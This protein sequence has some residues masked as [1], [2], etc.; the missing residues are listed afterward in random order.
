VYFL[1]DPEA[2]FNVMVNERLSSRTTFSQPCSNRHTRRL[3]ARVL[4]RA[5]QPDRLPCGI[6]RGPDRLLIEALL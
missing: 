1:V 4:D 5:G 2:G 3:R 6:G